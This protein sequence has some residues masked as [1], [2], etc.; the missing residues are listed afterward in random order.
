MDW[1]L[2]KLLSDALLFHLAERVTGSNQKQL[3]NTKITVVHVIHP[4]K[5]S[6]ISITYVY[7]NSQ[8]CLFD[9]PD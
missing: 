5:S 7:W 8:K 2:Q 3:D 1:L 9:F 6:T 4:Q